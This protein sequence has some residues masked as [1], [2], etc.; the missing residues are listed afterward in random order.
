MIGEHGNGKLTRG[1]HGLSRE[2][3]SAVQRARLLDAMARVVAEQGYVKTSVAAVLRRSGVGRE[4]FYELFTDKQDCFLAAY[5][6]VVERLGTATRQALGD[7]GSALER[8]SRGLASYLN[9]LAAEPELART[10]LIEVYAAGPVAL[11]KRA[12]VQRLFVDAMIGILGVTGERDR[13]ACEALVAATS[14][15]VTTR[16][17]A[18]GGATLPELHE[19]LVGL[20]RELFGARPG[21]Q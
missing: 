13:F 20:A 18:G 11:A 8:W 4:T 3:V 16:L 17:G 12:T 1:R 21:E 9:T 19:P 10:F 7:T 2:Q 15:L 6:A 5:D 14:S